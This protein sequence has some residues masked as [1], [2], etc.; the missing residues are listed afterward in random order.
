MRP[1]LRRDSRFLNFPRATLFTLL[2][3]TRM[4]VGN[5]DLRAV[6][7]GDGTVKGVT[8]LSGNPS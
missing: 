3:L 1:V 4:L 5:V 7:R 6:I 8:V 2:S